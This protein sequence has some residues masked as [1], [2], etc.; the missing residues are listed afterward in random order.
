MDKPIIYDGQGEEQDWDWLISNFG[1]ISLE[2][3]EVTEG[4]TRVY[5]VMKLQ[6]AEGPA[7]QIVN[8]VDQDSHPLEGIHVVR[9]WPD[10]PELPEWPPPV[11]RWYDRGVYGPTN[12]NGDIGF[13]M[14]SG[15][16]YFPPSAGASAVWVADQNGPSDVISGLGML[17]ASNHR[18]L[19]V[20]FQLKDVEEP[21]PPPPPPPPPESNWEK[22]FDK[23]DR[24]IALLEEYLEE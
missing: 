11:S 16:Y 18:H 1:N 15:D 7:T 24:I 13:G 5:R 9:Y 2:R 8:V 17:G 3:S 20:Y 10:A 14:G 22:L 21:P 12:V 19:N 23:L 4:V 6:D